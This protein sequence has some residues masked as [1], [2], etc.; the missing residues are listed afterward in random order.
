MF[1]FSGKIFT[2]RSSANRLAESYIKEF[3]R[4]QEYM[5]IYLQFTG[6]TSAALLLIEPILIK[7]IVF[8]A[9]YFF[10]KAGVRGYVQKIA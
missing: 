4:N 10:L 7:M 3:L 5:A 2:T 8:A 1:R 6:L 9:S